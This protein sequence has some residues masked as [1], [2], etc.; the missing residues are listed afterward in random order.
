MDKKNFAFGKKNFLML[1]IKMV[2]VIIGFV[3]MSGGGSD[4]STFNNDIF[5]PLRIR[6]APLICLIGYVSIIYAIICKPKD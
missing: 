1:A 3:M 2:I 4:E 5:S 6:I